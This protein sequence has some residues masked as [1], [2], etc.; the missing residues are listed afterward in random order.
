MNKQVA[1]VLGGGGA[2]GA[3]QVGALQALLE[4][5]LQPD[6]LVGTSIGAVNA[7]FLALHGYSK[8]S[9]DLLTAAWHKAASIDLLPVNYVWL[10][11]RAMFGRSSNNPSQRIKDFFI[12]HGL[13]PELRFADIKQPRLII[14]SADLNT[15]RPVLHGTSPDEEILAALLVST[16]LPPWVMPVRKRNQYLMDG[17]VVSNLPIEPALTA[18]ATE[19]IALDLID[20]RELFR[21]DN[22]LGSFVDRLTFAMEKRQTDLELEL[23]KA[24]GIPITYI[25]LVGR[26]PVPFWDFRYTDELIV[27]GYEIARGTIEKYSSRLIQMI[28]A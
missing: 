18:G 15:G 12:A 22:S 21:P 3:L 7:T 19:I 14:V 27:Q 25:D 5:G 10:T 16:A 11:V 4:Y 23:A 2:R 20:E 6:L 28:Q 17:G 26:N 9:L 24:R 1:F 13:T 8:Q